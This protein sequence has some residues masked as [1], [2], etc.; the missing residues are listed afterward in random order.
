MHET[1]VHGKH[2]N[3]DSDSADGGPMH[4]FPHGLG[5]CMGC[6]L[7]YLAQLFVTFYILNI[8]WVFLGGKY[9]RMSLVKKFQ[10]IGHSEPSASRLTDFKCIDDWLCCLMM[11]WV[12]AWMIGWL[13]LH[14]QASIHLGKM[15][16]GPGFLR[17][18]RK[19][20]S[21]QNFHFTW[22]HCMRYIVWDTP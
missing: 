11:S 16:A 10:S 12:N 20:T 7:E 2:V 17:I 21:L 5:S 4:P 19:T 9:E 3:A 8:L 15:Q 14:W 13:C 6:L 1:W 22:Q 18:A